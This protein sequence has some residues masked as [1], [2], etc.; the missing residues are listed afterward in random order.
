MFVNYE[1]DGVV[2]DSF[3]CYLFTV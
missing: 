2:K 1:F 3:I